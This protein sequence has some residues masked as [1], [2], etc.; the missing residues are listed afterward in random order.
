MSGTFD[1][2]ISYKWQD[3][4]D[5]AAKLAAELTAREYTA[6][7]DNDQI[8][9]GDSILSAIEDGMKSAIDAV[10]VISPNYFSGWAD[11]ER[12]ALFHMMTARKLRIV[13]LHFGVT[14]DDVQ[15]IA[16]LFA[17]IKAITAPDDSPATITAA[18]DAIARSYAPGQRRQRLFEMF[19]RCVSEKFPDDW[20]L[21]LFLAVFD[22]DADKVREA[23]D[24]GAD[25]NVTDGALWNR[26]NR[27]A[28]ECGCFDEWRK[29]YLFLV[30]QGEVGGG[31]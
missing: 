9:P 30:E 16:P 1:F 15:K 19:F 25:V 11:Q 20:D 21:K 28:V 26:Y 3:S 29:L 18:C 4:Q 13:P 6:W 7:L 24:A 23:C 10:V 2:F 22:D 12:R 14:Y 27:L 8:H 31:A 17:D 5:F